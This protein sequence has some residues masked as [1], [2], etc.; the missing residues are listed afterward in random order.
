MR[1]QEQE[2]TG[3]ANGLMDFDGHVEHLA[4]PSR[5][6]PAEGVNSARELHSSA[7]LRAPGEWHVM[8][9]R[10]QGPLL[11]ATTLETFFS[12]MP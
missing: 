11:R 8:R 6:V 2:A 1:R 9:R 7:S 4:V 3:S 10:R 12:T 5:A